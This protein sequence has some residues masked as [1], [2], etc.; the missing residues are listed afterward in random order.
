[1]AKVDDVNQGLVTPEVNQH[2]LAMQIVV[3]DQ[4]P[5]ESQDGVREL[6]GD[7]EQLAEGQL[8]PEDDVTERG[9]VGKEFHDQRGVPG[10]GLA[11]QDTQESGHVARVQE[12]GL[13][14][15]LVQDLTVPDTET[16]EVNTSTAVTA[17]A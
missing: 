16:T 9:E 3:Q 6:V 12:V 10:A 17:T 7:V 8:I 5:V 4:L 11:R 15:A 1:M 14:G 2:I 13:D